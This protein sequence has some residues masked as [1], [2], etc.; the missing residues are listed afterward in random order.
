MA[1][2]AY[3][4][5][6]TEDLASGRHDWRAAGHTFKIALT[7]T[8]PDV[9]SDTVLAD[10]AEIAATGGYVAGGYDVQNDLSRTGNTTSLLGTDI[11]ITASG[12]AIGPFRYLVL[13]NDT[14]TG[15]RL[16]SVTDNGASQS[17]VDGN[18]YIIDIGATLGTAAL[19]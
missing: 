4:E 17:I 8:A 19:A 16:V 3:F 15:D 11:T 13:Y 10:I 14:S 2:Q 7:N 18:S 9:A 5:C 6:Y 12:G 1:T